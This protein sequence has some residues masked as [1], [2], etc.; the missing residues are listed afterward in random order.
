MNIRNDFRQGSNFHQYNRDGTFSEESSGGNIHK[1]HF[2][3]ERS[4]SVTP[5]IKDVHGSKHPPAEPIK[6]L[7]ESQASNKDRSPIEIKQEFTPPHVDEPTRKMLEDRVRIKKRHHEQCPF[8]GQHGECF[9]P[10][11]RCGERAQYSGRENDQQHGKPHRCLYTPFF[12]GDNVIIVESDLLLREFLLD[13]FKLFLNYNLEKVSVVNSPEE[14]TAL[15]TKFKL[16]DRPIGLIILNC[17]TLGIG[18]SHLLDEIYDRNLSAE[19]ILTGDTPEDELVFP[20]EMK[21]RMIDTKLPF[22][23][24]YLQ[25]PIHTD[26][27]LATVHSLFFGRYL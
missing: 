6:P 26:H 25:T 8:T 27:L 15:L 24:A 14:A 18:A 19:I 20:E 2:S 16:Q 17:T 4:A 12:P 7:L 1:K 10:D 5:I 23:S 13:S 22:I 21:R 9:R 3:A 11:I